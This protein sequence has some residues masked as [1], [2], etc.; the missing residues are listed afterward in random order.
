MKKRKT[1]AVAQRYRVGMSAVIAA[2]LHGAGIEY[3]ERPTQFHLDGSVTV[4]LNEREL[5]IARDRLPG[6]TE[7]TS[8]SNSG[9]IRV[10]WDD[11]EF[12]FEANSPVLTPEEKAARKTTSG[13]LASQAE[14]D[15]RKRA[16]ADRMRRAAERHGLQFFEDDSEDE[17]N[18]D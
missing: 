2:S 15:E 13:R 3:D 5:A 12:Y 8:H 10:T 11:T 1:L 7:Y 17:D 4:T 18:E 6:W 16:L 14:I 9:A